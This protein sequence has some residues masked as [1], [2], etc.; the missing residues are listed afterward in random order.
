MTVYTPQQQKLVGWDIFRMR[1]GVKGGYYKGLSWGTQ[2]R[3]TTEQV[4]AAWPGDSFEHN[5]L[6]IATGHRSGVWVLDVD[7]VKE[8]HEEAAEFVEEVLGV[9]IP[10]TL[11]VR[12]ASGKW[13]FYF[14]MPANKTVT[15]KT[16]V[17]KNESG[18]PDE[19]DVRGDGGM[20]MGIGSIVE[21]SVHGQYEVIVSMKPVFAPIDLLKRT[22][23][24]EEQRAEKK[25]A[26]VPATIE[27]NVDPNADERAR[28]WIIEEITKLDNLPRPWAEGSG[29][30]DTCFKVACNLNELANSEWCSLTPEEAQSLYFE[31]APAPEANWNPMHE[32]NEGLKKTDG[33]ARPKPVDGGAWFQEI[34][35]SRPA[36][37]AD[38]AVSIKVD[39]DDKVIEVK[40]SNQWG[41]R[42]PEMQTSN[43]PIPLAREFLKLIPTLD[44]VPLLASYNGDWYYYTGSHWEME[45]IRETFDLVAHAIADVKI[46]EQGEDGKP[47]F[48][49]LNPG[50]TKITDIEEAGLG[51]LLR[52]REPEVRADEKVVYMANGSLHL[53]ADGSYELKPVTPSV[54]NLASLPFD[55]DPMAKCPDWE[56]F[57]KDTF[58][59]DPKAIDALQEWFGYFLIGRPGWMQKMFWLIGPRR[60]GKGT[61]L[62]VARAMMGQAATATSLHVMAQDFGPANMIG[63]NLAIIDD[64]RDP[65]PRIAHR[66]VEFL[67]TA[68]SGGFISINRKHRD[69]WD[70]VLSS[71]IFGA[72]NIVPRFPDAGSAI[73]SRLEVIKT[74]QS[75]LGNE[76]RSLAVRLERELPGIL[77]WSLKGLERL[78]E[79]G[80][81]TR[82][83]ATEEIIEQVDR[84]ATG[85]T[86]MVK[87]FMMAVDGNFGMSG[88]HLKDLAAWWATQQ[89]DDYRPNGPAI[90][91][92][93]LAEFPDVATRQRTQSPWGE[94]I[95]TGYR[96]IAAKCRECDNPAQRI[97]LS[98]GPECNIH[99]TTDMFSR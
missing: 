8:T 41:V 12:T 45:S 16:L 91:S 23:I 92:A 24:T 81:F 96:G 69:A 37:D 67:L 77:N 83:G 54:F 3:L 39:G 34:V 82:S 13:H 21:G 35:T 99:L 29:W 32:W 58:A 79:Q 97:S 27:K 28:K 9:R 36:T 2:E 55:Y 53:H 44:D 30:H 57:L 68:T 18:W 22:Q 47:V 61:I 7:V 94:K 76:D 5:N 75:H 51:P 95:A 56:V 93:I 73:S 86:P 48:K 50:K 26:A 62:N 88:A 63:K 80:Y 14:A 25:A 64:A 65:D 85:A 10:E 33:S 6:G 98:F 17:G 11:T 46:V 78:Q 90:K 60:S 71:V 59:H 52:R 42:L 20:A 70:G 40:P 43:G 31:H 1:P 15:I 66:V 74:K 49:P 87:D 84:G 72:S 38:R 89:E 19:I 4:E